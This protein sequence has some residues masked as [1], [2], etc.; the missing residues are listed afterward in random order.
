[1]DDG[2]DPVVPPAAGAAAA[3]PAGAGG[4]T[5]LASLSARI[6]QIEQVLAMIVQQLEGGGE[7][8][9]DPA[10]S[11][12]E[13]EPTAPV[14]DPDKVGGDKSVGDS[15]AKGKPRTASVGDSTSLRPGFQ[16]MV[17]QAETLMP[18]IAM[19]TFDSARPAKSTFS[20]MC[21]FRRKTLEASVKTDAGK[22]AISAVVGDSLPASFYDA[23][24]TC[25]TISAVFNAAA[26]LMAQENNGRAHT[27]S[28]GADGRRNG[29]GAKP[30]TPAELNEKARA[31][32]ANQA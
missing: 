27:T 30:P 29:F 17:S 26:V 5:D 2:E 6:D 8:E 28:L 21:A 18:G 12:P 31:F 32:Y 14:E 7:E 22:R 9:A 19:M 1:M 4:G 25:D 23:S 15:V 3:D 13:A 16:I 11:E 20:D 10:S 24:M